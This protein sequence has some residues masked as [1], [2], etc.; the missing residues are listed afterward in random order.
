MTEELLKHVFKNVAYFLEAKVIT[1]DDLK[2][3]KYPKEP[4]RTQ[5]NTDKLPKAR[6]SASDQVVTGFSLA[7]DWLTEWR[8][9]SGPFVERS[10]TKGKQTHIVFD[11]NK[12][13]R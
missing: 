13:M 12:Y 3:G 9:F 11:T 2:K 8:E 5:S 6:E 1:T 4:M 10:K 7:S